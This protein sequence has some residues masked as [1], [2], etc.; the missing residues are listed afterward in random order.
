MSTPRKPTKKQITSVNFE[1]SLQ[2]LNMLVEKMETGQLTLETSLSYFEEGIT[3]I[4]QCQKT[5]NEA[6]QKVEI[7]TKNE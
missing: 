7:L 5:L 1:K 4:R 3:L 6:E 2:Q